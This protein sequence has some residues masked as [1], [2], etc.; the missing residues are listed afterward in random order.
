MVVSYNLQTMGI[1]ANIYLFC[2]RHSF[3]VSAV[4]TGSLISS[5]A[6][7]FENRYFHFLFFGLAKKSVDTLEH[8]TL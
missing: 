1:S 6:A 8:I 5:T 7:A 4:G 2:V 3:A